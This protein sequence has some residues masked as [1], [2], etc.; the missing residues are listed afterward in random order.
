MRVTAYSHANYQQ[1]TILHY[2]LWLCAREVSSPHSREL[3]AKIVIA[4]KA[5]KFP[6]PPLLADD[7]TQYIILGLIIQVLVYQ[8]SRIKNSKFMN[9]ETIYISVFINRVEMQQNYSIFVKI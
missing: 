1:H 4:A 9:Q 8:G 7:E 3:L 5:A 6:F 2:S